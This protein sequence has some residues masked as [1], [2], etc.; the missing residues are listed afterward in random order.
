MDNKPWYEKIYIWLG[1]VA[2]ICAILGISILGGFLNGNK[3]KPSNKIN[4]SDHELVIN[5]SNN[6]VNYGKTEQDSNQNSKPDSLPA[7]EASMQE[8]SGS[9]KEERYY[10]GTITKTGWESKFIGLRY[11]NPDGMSMA[12]KEELDKMGKFDDGTPSI[13]FSPD[14]LGAA[15]LTTAGEMMSISDDRSI[16]VVVC[17]E[18]LI[19]KVDVPRYIEDFKSQLYR[20]P[21]VNYTLISDDETVKIGNDDY[22]AVSYITES[23]HVF[24]YQDS[25]FRIVGDRVIKIS[26]DF[27]DEGARDNI[28]DAFTAY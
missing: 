27:N 28:L 23:N 9:N 25:Y 17:V 18:R 11:T 14:E 16:S 3:D 26:L 4:T 20:N 5:G 12:T 7:S 6:T 15:K 24:R 8:T 22:I 2:S 19:D 13:V 21:F 10:Q 1:I